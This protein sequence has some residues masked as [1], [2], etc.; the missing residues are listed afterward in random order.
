V[1]QGVRSELV[2]TSKTNHAPT[3]SAPR[4]AQFPSQRAT[5]WLLFASS[6]SCS[7]G[8]SEG[9][10]ERRSF[11]GRSYMALATKSRTG[12]VACAKTES[13]VDTAVDTRRL[14]LSRSRLQS[15]LPARH[16]ETLHLPSGALRYE[17]GERMEHVLPSGG[18]MA[19]ANAAQLSRPERRMN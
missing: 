8:M 1:Q 5:R 11:H 19:L 6:E 16:A 12:C 9:K 14:S 2:T 4:L 17:W 15:R 13:A 3:D 7:N 10:N 18:R